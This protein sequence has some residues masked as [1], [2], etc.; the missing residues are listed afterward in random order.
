[1]WKRRGDDVD[2]MVKKVLR[3]A[4]K[5][6][7]KKTVKGKASSAKKIGVLSPSNQGLSMVHSKESHF[8]NRK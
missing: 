3:K 2:E 8:S 5:K 4:K 7:Q 6:K 1:M